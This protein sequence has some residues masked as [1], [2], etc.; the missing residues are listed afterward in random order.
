[1]EG[2]DQE[3]IDQ[4]FALFDELLRDLRKA[5]K[6]PKHQFP[7]SLT[8]TGLDV[9]KWTHLSKLKGT[10][11]TAEQHSV[12][13]QTD[14]RRSRRGDGSMLRLQFRLFEA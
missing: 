11:T 12:S 14:P 9:L 10:N 8:R 1:M 6:R 4:Y 5:A 13:G 3:V 7:L 2:T